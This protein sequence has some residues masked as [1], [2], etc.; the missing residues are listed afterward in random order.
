M[1][2]KLGSTVTRPTKQYCDSSYEADGQ[3]MSPD[4]PTATI[5][6]APRRFDLATIMV[7]TLAYALLLAGLRLLRMPPSGVLHV[8]G[9]ITCV[10]IGQALLFRGKRPRLSSILVGVAYLVGSYV[11]DAVTRDG[12]LL[13]PRFFCADL[14]IHRHGWRSRWLSLGNRRRIGLPFLRRGEEG[15]S[16]VQAPLRAR[17]R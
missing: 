4:A 17:G 6:S 8:A 16:T 11:I 12:S 9:C 14:A 13:D 10:G 5:Y 15:D 2:Y 1:S 7:V 3:T